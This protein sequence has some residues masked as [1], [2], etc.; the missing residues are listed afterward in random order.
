MTVVKFTLVRPIA[1]T[2]TYKRTQFVN[3]FFFYAVDYFQLIWMYY[4]LHIIVLTVP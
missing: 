3:H 1:V 4:P 2:I